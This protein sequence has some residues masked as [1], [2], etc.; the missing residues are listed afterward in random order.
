M[1]TPRTLP[2]PK[3]YPIVGSLPDLAKDPMQFLFGAQRQHGDRFYYQMM[4]NHVYFLAHPDDIKH[5]LQDNHRNYYKHK[6][7]GL[8]KPL[9]GEGLLTSEGETWLTNRRLI[10][11]VFHRQRIA[12]F[13]EMMQESTVALIETRLRN[14]HDGRAFDLLPEMMRLT[15][16]VVARA[17]F[18]RDISG[19]ADEVGR[20]LSY[21][22]EFT[23][24]RIM[25]AI[26]VPLSVPTPANQTFQRALE[27][28]DGVVLGMIQERRQSAEEQDDLLGMLL[29]AQDADTGEGMSDRQVRDEAM[30]LFLAGHETSAA[31]LTWLFYLLSRHVAV[32]DKLKD[33]IAQVLQGRAVTLDDLPQL[34]YTR[35]VIDET[36]RL[37][38]PAWMI[39]RYALRDDMLPGKPVAIPAGTN[40]SV[41]PYVTHRHSQFWD[42][43]EGFE[44]ERFSPERAKGRHRY[45]YFPF[46]GG[47][48]QCIG[49]TFALMEMTIIVATLMQHLN[50]ELVSGQTVIPDPGITMRP[51][52]GLLMRLRRV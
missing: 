6:L 47:P 16:T 39:G 38:P 33:E 50:L 18:S 4:N 24:R 3:R 20:A 35:M 44:P 21:A 5:V 10:Q 41:S 8:V 43:P 12:G 28:L 13:A 49:N 27:T 46:A 34:G 22:L 26:P 7:Y 45:A 52:G 25:S 17:L 14:Y 31:A 42:N 23:N 40:V 2:G 37:Y 30:T 19:D 9:I 29:S 36:L 11:P 1:T 48:R 15:L 51:K 32:Y